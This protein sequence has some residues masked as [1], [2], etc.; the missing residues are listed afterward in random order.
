MK[1]NGM[2]RPV[3]SYR[4]GQ[5]ILEKLATTYFHT[6]ILRHTMVYTLF[7]MAG[8]TICGIFSILSTTPSKNPIAIDHE[9]NITYRGFS[10]K[11]VDSF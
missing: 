9:K 2:N 1:L 10:S 3:L 6:A 5:D 11:G 7:F 8:L 4:R